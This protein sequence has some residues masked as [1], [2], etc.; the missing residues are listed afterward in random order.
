[1]ASQRKF[2]RHSKRSPAAARYRNESRSSRNKRLNEEKAAA[3]KK[4]DAEKQMKIP[5]GSA[6]AARRAT[7][8]A[9]RHKAALRA[10]A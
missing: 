6:R 2:G 4:A 10:L 5:R 1:M 3:Q 8:P 7:D 9:V